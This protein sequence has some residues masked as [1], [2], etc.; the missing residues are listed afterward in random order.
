MKRILTIAFAVCL[1]AAVLGALDEKTA[2]KA[3]DHGV[4]SPADIQWGDAPPS[5]PPGVKAAVLEGDPSQEGLFTLRLKAPDGYRI[6]PHWHPAFEHVTVISGTFRIGMGEKFDESKMESIPAGGFG[7][8]AP[9]MRHYG[10]TKGET[11]VQVH[12]MGPWQLYYVNPS[13]D[14]RQAK[15]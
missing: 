5:L 9:G 13:D 8:M 15:K 1:C 14:P 2:M 11:V 6:P 10:M 7:F 4:F 12:A 3:P